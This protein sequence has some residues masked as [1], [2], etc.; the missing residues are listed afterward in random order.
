[1]VDHEPGADVRRR[2]GPVLALLFPLLLLPAAGAHAQDPPPAYPR[3]GAER[4]LENEDVI[5]WNIAW[6][7]QAYPVHRHRYDHVGVYYESGNRIIVSTEGERRPVTTEAWNISFQRRGVTH[8]EEGASAEP[9]R[10]VFIQMKREPRRAPDTGGDVTAFP[11]GGPAERLDN[12]RVRV[13]EYGPGSASDPGRHRHV[14][15]AVVVSFDSS[16]DPMVRWVARGT[17]H[18]SDVREGAART[19]VFEIE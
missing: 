5:V 8:S 17:V 12:D 2:P 10:A 14:H 19:L 13:W 18:E 9:L 6:L 16:N 7:E 11:V 15:D 3:P 1:M 4:M